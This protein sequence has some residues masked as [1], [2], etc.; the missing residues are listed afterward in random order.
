MKN[1]FLNIIAGL[2]ISSLAIIGCNNSNRN[3]TYSDTTDQSE[4]QYNNM[5]GNNGNAD[6]SGM[7]QGGDN[8]IGRTGN[9]T[10]TGT[11]TGRMGSSSDTSTTNY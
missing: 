8:G 10:E 2:A 6:T 4:A 3:D 9:G 5:P 1:N 7:N 11:G